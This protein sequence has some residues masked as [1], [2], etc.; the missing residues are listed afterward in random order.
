MKYDIKSY[1]EEYLDDHARI[2]AD[3]RN[4]W[5]I[6]ERPDKGQIKTNF[7]RKQSQPD[8]DPETQLYAFDDGRIIGFITSSIYEEDGV[9]KGDLRMPFVVEGYEN[10]RDL[11]LAR[12]IEVLRT[13]GAISIRTLVS[14]YWG[15]TVSVAKRNGFKFDKNFVIQSQ[16]RFDEI[17]EK[18]LVEPKDVQNFEYRKHAEALTKLLMKQFNV[19]YEEARPVVKRFK[20]WEIGATKNPIGVPQRLI[21]HGLIIDNEE[22]VGR[23]LG[24]QQDLSGEKTIDLSLYAKNNNKE[25]LSQLLTA[26]IR[27]SKKLRMDVLHIGLR[28]PTEEIK[29]FYS[30]YGLI[31]RTAAAYYTKEE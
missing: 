26:G 27:E 30:S 10:A 6:I 20:D 12:V 18:K 29:G 25:I 17:D 31:F 16:K 23:H 14:E 28:T 21:T 19:S 8:F 4:R 11:L 2:E 15:Q 24:F 22:A 9:I 1:R 3:E 5:N 13:K 7:T